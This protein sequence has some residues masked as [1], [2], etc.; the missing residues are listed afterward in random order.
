MFADPPYN[1]Q[2][3]HDL[4]RPDMSKVDA[5]RDGWDRFKDF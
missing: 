4:Y 2:L 3:Q 5:V 1:L